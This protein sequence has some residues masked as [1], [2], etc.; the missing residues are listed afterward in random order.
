MGPS[1]WLIVV[2]IAAWL[3]WKIAPS[4]RRTDPPATGGAPASLDNPGVIRIATWNIRQFG[5]NS[6]ADIAMIARIILES[7]FDLVAIQE[8]KG[9][10]ESVDRLLVALGPPWR[11]TRLSP[12]TGN[13]QRFAFVYR[14]DRL[15]ELGRPRFVGPPEVEPP[16]LGVFD[17]LP[18]VASF[19]AGNFD[20][21][22][23]N[24]HL[25]Y[26][27]VSRRRAEA[28]ALAS[29]ARLMVETGS[30][31]DPRERDLILL[32]DFNEE[33][34]RRTNLPALT[35]GGW[36]AVIDSPTN[37][38]SREI[39]DNIIL[40]PRTAGEYTGNDGVVFFDELWL[41]NDDDLARER[42]S[43]HRPAWAEFSTRGPD[44]D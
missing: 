17:R 29:L 8:I 30:H 5:D 31:H 10:G 41:G 44:D 4:D 26:S 38:T 23:V 40:S 20:F 13:N 21:T 7:G 6:R 11:S 2:L 27:D 42:V 43:D 22:L 1:R 12:V 28:N 33:G 32:G 24:V 14:G 16:S 25:F 34:G 39:Y 19:K 36:L 35:A 9:T 15:S 18:Y 37:L 3:V